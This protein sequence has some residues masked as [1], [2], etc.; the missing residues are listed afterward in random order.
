LVL[1]GLA[2]SAVAAYA[3]RY[4]LDFEFNDPNDLPQGEG[5][6]RHFAPAPF[7]LV[8]DGVLTYDSNDPQS[9]DYFEYH[10]PGTFDPGPGQIFLCE[11]ELQTEWVSYWGDPGVSIKSDDAWVVSLAFDVNVVHSVHDYVDISIPPGQ[12][13]VYTLLSNSMRTYQFFIDGVL[14]REGSFAHRFITSSLQFGD[15]VQG[16][17]SRHSWDFMKCGV[18]SAPQIA[19]GDLDCS[20]VVDF[21]DINPFVQA[22]IDP[23]G[24]MASYPACPAENG[25]ILPGAVNIEQLYPAA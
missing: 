25:D 19:P 14:A 22:L 17:A 11:W 23:V 21:G 10:R 15:L 16:E 24:Y 18:V 2:L 4:W 1:L 8:Q 6:N 3:D 9:Y 12:W 20:G 13:H 5:W 7:G